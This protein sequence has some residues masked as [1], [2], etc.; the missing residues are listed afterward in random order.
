MDTVQFKMNLPLDVKQWIEHEARVTNR[1]Q[2]AMVVTVLRA[3]MPLDF[4][5]EQDAGAD[6]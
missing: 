4:K 3:A 1:S 2:S 6:Q 5:A